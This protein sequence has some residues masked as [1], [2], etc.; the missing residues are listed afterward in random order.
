MKVFNRPIELGGQIRKVNGED[1]RV[2]EFDH[3]GM[4]S[5]ASGTT[6]PTGPGYAKG[7]LFTKTDALSGTKSVYENQGNTTTASFNLMGGISESEIED[8]AVTLAKLNADVVDDETLELT[9]GGLA[10]KSVVGQSIADLSPDE[11]PPLDSAISTGVI[12]LTGNGIPNN[13]D[14]LT[15][16]SVV[17]AFATALSTGPTVPNEI[18]IGSDGEDTLN[19][20]RAALQAGAG[21]G[22][23]YSTG[24]VENSDVDVPE[25]AAVDGD[26]TL[27]IFARVGGEA[28]D[29]IV[30]DD[31]ANN[32]VTPGFL[33]GG[34]D[35]T[36]GAVGS[37]L[38]TEDFLYVAI[39]ENTVES[40]VW[41][42]AALSVLS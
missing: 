27:G 5:R 2:L 8:E 13:E 6:V 26:A 10:V 40:A 32:V 17:Y 1:I 16:G 29:A 23:K 14:S 31:D 25:V 9:A 3:E 12:T 37:F 11:D 42:E 39:Q 41:R 18:L 33:S 20:V 4:I 19:N 7:A 35:G 24:T 38:Y 28:G 21:I 22:V 36:P 34:E 15:V 30:L